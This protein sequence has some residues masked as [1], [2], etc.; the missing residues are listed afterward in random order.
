MIFT[1]S[2][3]LWPGIW[4]WLSWRFWLSLSQSQKTAI[5]VAAW[6][7]WSHLKL[8]SG[9]DSLPSSLLCLLLEFSFLGAVGLTASVLYWLL[10]GGHP[11]VLPHRHLNR[12]AHKWWLA[13]SELEKKRERECKVEATVF[14]NIIL[15]V[16]SITFAR[17]YSLEIGH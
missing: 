10:S 9:R 6:L 14:Y 5:K 2:Q 16:T 15:E 13:L 7:Q 8:Q 1:I 12:A 3:F 17:F 11:Q 4:A